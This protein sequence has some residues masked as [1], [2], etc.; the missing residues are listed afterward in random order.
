MS[1]KIQPGDVIK[2]YYQPEEKAD[3]REVSA[4]DIV[5]K[6][7]EIYED[8]QKYSFKKEKALREFLMSVADGSQIIEAARSSFNALL[9]T[10]R[11][12][13]ISN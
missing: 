10:N 7:K 2:D 1:E 8:K 13:T 11:N 9:G 6:A 4:T 5:A 3:G 12:R